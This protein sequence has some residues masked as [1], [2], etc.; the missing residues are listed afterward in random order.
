[1]V[2]QTIRTS[3]AGTAIERSYSG[4]VPADHQ[5][6]FHHRHQLQ[7]ITD[8][9]YLAN[10]YRSIRYLDSTNPKGYSLASQ[11]Y[12]DTHT[13]AAVQIQGKYYL[14]YRAAITGIYRR[15]GDTWE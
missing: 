2:P 11:V 7:V 9:G 13:S 5:Q 12:P 3:R 14:P 8:A 15:Y 4:G 6:E 1:M 10:P